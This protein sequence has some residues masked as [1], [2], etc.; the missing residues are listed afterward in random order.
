MT[1]KSGNRFS[2][3]VMRKKSPQCEEPGLLRGRVL[4]K[5]MRRSDYE[6]TRTKRTSPKRLMRFT[7]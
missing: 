4:G 3:K 7:M 2:D 1:P 6:Q 5:Q